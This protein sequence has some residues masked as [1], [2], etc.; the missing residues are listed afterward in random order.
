MSEAENHKKKEATEKKTIAAIEYLAKKRYCRKPPNFPYAAALLTYALIERQIKRYIGYAYPNGPAILKEVIEGKVHYTLGS[1]IG[2]K[3]PALPI[4][5]QKLPHFKQELVD[6]RNEVIHYNLYH[7]SEPAYKLFTPKRHKQHE[8]YLDVA[9]DHLE[10]T[11]ENYSK[12]HTFDKNNF[13]LK[14]KPTESGGKQ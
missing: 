10:W 8:H 14:A 4:L 6:D 11:F 13:E 5:K 2:S 3:R 9:L 12:Y 1:L 7:K